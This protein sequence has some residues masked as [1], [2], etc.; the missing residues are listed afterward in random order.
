MLAADGPGATPRSRSTSS[1][2]TRRPEDALEDEPF[3]LRERYGMQMLRDQLDEH[4]LHIASSNTERWD[5][6]EGPRVRVFTYLNTS[7]ATKCTFAPPLVR[8]SYRRGKSCAKGEVL[9]VEADVTWNALRARSRSAT[10]TRTHRRSL[11]RATGVDAKRH[12]DQ[13]PAFAETLTPTTRRDHRPDRAYRRLA[14]DDAGERSVS[15]AAR[16]TCPSKGSSRPLRHDDQERWDRWDPNA[17]HPRTV[18]VEQAG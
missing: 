17:A 11:A 10:K 5:D 18:L 6:F 8:Q 1:R 7:S 9:R 14:S 16:S 4:A 3:G 13:V 15:F 12:E 2:L